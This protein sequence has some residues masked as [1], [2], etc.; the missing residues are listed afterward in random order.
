ML[1]LCLM[2]LKTYYGQNYAG[3]I[4]LGLSEIYLYGT[5]LPYKQHVCTC[6]DNKCVQQ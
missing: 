2:L 5:W 1:A 6:V 3:I 4:G